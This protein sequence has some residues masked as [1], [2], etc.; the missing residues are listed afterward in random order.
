VF[1]F[2]IVEQGLLYVAR[3]ECEAVQ[4]VPFL[5][6]CQSLSSNLGEGLQTTYSN[7]D[8]ESLPPNC[9]TFDNLDL[10]RLLFDPVFGRKLSLGDTRPK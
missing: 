3:L 10:Q 5:L 7:N 2:V 1:V 4:V 6:G 8:R 9:S